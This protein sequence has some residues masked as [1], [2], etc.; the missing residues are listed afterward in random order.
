[1][2]Y[3]ENKYTLWYYGYDHNTGELVQRHD[4]FTGSRY[5]CYK[6]RATK[7]FRWQYKVKRSTFNQ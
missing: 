4:V 1:M 2:T 7:S 5:A 6:L 3:T